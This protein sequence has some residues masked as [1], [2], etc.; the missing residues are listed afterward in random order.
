MSP[1]PVFLG[2][3]VG[4]KRDRAAWVGVVPKRLGVGDLPTWSVVVCE[5]APLGTLYATIASRTLDIASAFAGGGWPVLVAVDATGIGAAVVE[6]LRSSPGHAEIL[7]VT[8]HGG[9]NVTGAW[10]DVG[11]P[12]TVLVAS[13]GE[14]VRRRALT[15]TPGLPATDVLRAQLKTYVAKCSP[16][17]DGVGVRVRYEAEHE[18][19][20]DDTV[21]AAQLAI[22]AGSY[23]F[24]VL[25]KM[26]PGKG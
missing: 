13:L 25:S 9:K 21:S 12:K 18:R 20:H 24:G 6:D 14:V 26:A 5:Q 17:R 7:A 8:A 11:V 16:G 4:K 1:F 22:Y 2:L 3:D 10:P 15:V 19:D 23:W